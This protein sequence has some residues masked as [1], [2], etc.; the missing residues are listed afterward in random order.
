M[1]HHWLRQLFGRGPRRPIR[2]APRRPRLG[3]G[4]EG[5]ES[6]EVPAFLT[7]ASYAAGANPAGI[8]VGDLNGDGRDDMA[9]VSNTAAGSVGVMLSNADGSFGARVDFATSTYPFDAAAGDLNGDGHLDLVVVGT[10][11]DVLLG[12]GD[13]TF[14]A[15]V[16]YAG[17]APHSVKVSTVSSRAW[18]DLRM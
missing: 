1:F 8:A 4:L 5:L 14:A 3:L 13:G 2:N 12:A 16:T 6:R 9:I 10:A 7:P 15:A 11:V 18:I 17:A